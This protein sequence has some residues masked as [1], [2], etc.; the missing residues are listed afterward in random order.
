MQEDSGGKG[1]TPSGPHLPP[2]EDPARPAELEREEV[3]DE[4]GSLFGGW[5]HREAEVEVP[6][7]SSSTQTGD[8]I[9][10]LCKA[11]MCDIFSP[12]RVGVEAAKFGMKVGMR[13]TSLPGGVSP[14]KPIVGRL[15]NMWIEKNHWS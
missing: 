9:E 10:H 2:D 8:L 3:E 7:D 1:G 4:Q 5:E 12:P 11:D 15:R 6:H 14:E 13:W